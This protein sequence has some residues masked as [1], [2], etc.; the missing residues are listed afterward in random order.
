MKIGIVLAV[1]SGLCLIYSLFYSGAG[2]GQYLIYTAML[3]WGVIRIVQAIK[4][5]KGKGVVKNE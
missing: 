3:V 2:F 1:P 5:N 4:R